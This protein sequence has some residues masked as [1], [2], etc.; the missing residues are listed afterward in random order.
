MSDSLWP[1]RLQDAR[2]PCP[3]LS[4]RACSN[5]CSLSWWCYPTISS[6][7]A[8]FSSCPQSF[9][10]SGSFPM[11]QLFTSG[12]QSTGASE[13]ILPMN[14]QDWFPL[15]LIGLISLQSKGVSSIFSSTTIQKQQ[16]FGA[17]PSLWS[18][19]HHLP[20]LF[21][22]LPQLPISLR[23]ESKVFTK[24]YQALPDLSFTSMTSSPTCLPFVY[25]T[26]ITLAFPRLKSR[27]QHSSAV[28]WRLWRPI[29]LKFIYVVGR[30]YFLV[31]WGLLS[32]FPCRLSVEAIL[33]S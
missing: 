1:H 29:C 23:E 15:G 11:S 22:T 33:I 18:N 17:Q 24:V 26:P 2:F 13:S 3:S 31:V 14:F 28:I 12:G 10:A 7:V 8:H 30:I 4:L 32:P 27:C 25:S 9:S 16:F 21:K 6:S 5:S 20:P 19:S